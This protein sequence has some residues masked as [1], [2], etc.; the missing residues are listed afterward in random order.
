MVVLAAT[1]VSFPLIAIG[2]KRDTTSTADLGLI[3]A[4]MQLVEQDYVH[5][6]SDDELTKDEE[7]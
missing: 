4:V 6:A 7:C 1:F 3:S 2:M 5:F